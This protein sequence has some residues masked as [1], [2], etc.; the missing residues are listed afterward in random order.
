MWR[1]NPC[2]LINDFIFLFL[3][4][5]VRNYKRKSGK[6]VFDNGITQ[7]AVH[8]VVENGGKIRTVARDMQLDRMTLTRY[9]KN[10]EMVKSTN[11]TSWFQN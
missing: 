8:E 10:S 1:I 5:M 7:S 3:D 4:V 11:R 6:G 2:H 9:V